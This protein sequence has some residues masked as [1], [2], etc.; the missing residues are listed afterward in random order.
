MSSESHS[1]LLM[2]GMTRKARNHM[3]R[4]MSMLHN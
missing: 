4:F 1:D 3:A 2:R